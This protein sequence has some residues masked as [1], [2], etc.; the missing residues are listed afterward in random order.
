MGGPGKSGQ[1]CLKGC[2]IDVFDGAADYTSYEETLNATTTAF[3]CLA[4]NFKQASCYHDA[5]M[6]GYQYADGASSDAGFRVLQRIDGQADEN[7]CSADADNVITLSDPQAT[8]C[9]GEPQG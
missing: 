9:L 5:P 2:D 7:L 4:P 1:K 3:L 6:T 8:F